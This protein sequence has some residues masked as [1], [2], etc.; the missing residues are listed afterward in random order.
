MT[1]STFQYRKYL[2]VL[3]L[4]QQ[5]AAKML[6]IDPRTSRRYALKERPIPEAI[7]IVLR[8]MLKYRLTADD[9]DELKQERLL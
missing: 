4:S 3:E 2:N 5:R 8:L 1:I 9:I 6:E 7:N